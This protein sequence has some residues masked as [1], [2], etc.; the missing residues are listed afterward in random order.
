MARQTLFFQTVYGT[1]ANTLS[2]VCT[3]L[4]NTHYC[5]VLFYFKC[6]GFSAFKQPVVPVCVSVSKYF[7]TYLDFNKN[8]LIYI[9]K[10]SSC[11]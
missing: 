6:R 3:F 2:V 8:V 1:A 11:L 5:F 7:V 10:I 9:L 4:R